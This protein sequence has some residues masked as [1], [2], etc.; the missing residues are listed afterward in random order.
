MDRGNTSP[1]ALILLLILGIESIVAFLGNGF[2]IVVNGHRWLQSRKMLPSDLLLTALGTTR[3]LLQ[4]VVAMSQWLEIYSAEVI[5]HSYFWESFFYAWVYFSSA[6][7][8]CATWL[9]VFYCVKVTNISHCLFL[10]L[11]PRIDKL[12]PRLIGLSLTVFSVPFA[13]TSWRDK[14]Y[15]SPTSNVTGNTSQGE[16]TNNYRRVFFIP[17]QFTFI[18]INVSIC[19]TASFLLLASLWRHTR[20]LKRSGIATKDFNTQAHISAV[21]SLL[22]FLFFYILYAIALTISLSYSFRTGVVK[23]LLTVIVLSLCPSVHSIILI[24]TNPKLKEMCVQI[25]KIRQRTS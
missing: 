14:N 8:W 21:N 18:A 6:S 23:G 24:L 10:W 13:A 1:F 4:V 9:S 11:K 12:V 17:L 20:N 22:S 7:V 15:C 19:L 16:D 3:F 25:L 2:I 5:C